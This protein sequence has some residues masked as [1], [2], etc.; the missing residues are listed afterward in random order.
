MKSRLSVE[1][2]GKIASVLRPLSKAWGRSQALTRS[3]G[4]EDAIFLVSGCALGLTLRYALRG[5]QSADFEG[6]TS[7]LYGLVKSGG[8]K[9]ALSLPT[10]SVSPPYLYLLAISSGLFANLHNI[11]AVKLVSVPF[12]FL[13]AFITA[14][15]IDLKYS[16]RSAAYV[17][18]MLVLFSPTVVLNGSFW[19]QSDIIY[20]TGLI[21]GL[22]FI[23]K[24]RETHAFVAFGLAFSFKPQAA[25]LAPVLLMLLLVKRASWKSVILIPL[26]WIVMMI[27]ALMAGRNL[28]DLLKI[29]NG[30]A[31]TDAMLT[32]NAPNLYQW[33]PN[34]LFKIS[35]PAGV[36]WSVGVILFFVAVVYTYRDRL[37]MTPGLIIELSA[38]SVLL[39][40]YILPGIHE[41]AFFAADILTIPFAF[42][43]PSYLIVPVLV[44][45]VSVLSYFPFLFG[46]EVIPMRTLAILELVP[47]LLLTYHLTSRL[48][49]RQSSAP[50][51][52]E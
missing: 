5:F 6:S 41:R 14:R 45:L 47:L 9:L 39:T 22:Y 23:L 50:R 27:P 38:I 28:I 44:Q 2:S 33:L 10:S 20:T 24:G 40:P 36:L 25:F 15:L 51:M 31:E 3:I 52:E 1:A 32:L 11:T 21:A 43:Y 7:E 26:T 49:H 4:F 8:V 18:F 30:Q 16:S 13:C 35:Y 19:G 48:K 29:Y 17:A 12:D 42:L 37:E 34:D 46:Y